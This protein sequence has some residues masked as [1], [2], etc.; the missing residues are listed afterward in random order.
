[1]PFFSYGVFEPSILVKH[2]YTWVWVSVKYENIRIT[3]DALNSSRDV[4]L[5]VEHFLHGQLCVNLSLD[6]YYTL[7]E[8]IGNVADVATSK[9]LDAGGYVLKQPFMVRNETLFR[10]MLRKALK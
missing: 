2:A 8:C 6:E 3:C 5:V 10:R 7:N 9:T 1:M 4:K